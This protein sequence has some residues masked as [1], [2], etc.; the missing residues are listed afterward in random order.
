MIDTLQKQL[1]L[2]LQPL[3]EYREC[4]DIL[5]QQ[6]KNYYLLADDG[7][8]LIGLNLNG[9]QL[10]A[11]QL[12]P[13]WA[14]TTL[15]YLN[16]SDNAFTRLEIPAEMQALVWLEVAD[17]KE[18]K[19]LEF[20]IGLGQLERLDVSDSQL[21]IF[22]LPAAFP[23]LKHIDASRNSIHK[24]D[25]VGILDNL[26]WIDFSNNKLGE[27]NFD[28][29]APSLEELY[30]HRSGLTH[31]QINYPYPKLKKLHL[32]DNKLGDYSMEVW[33]KLPLDME[34]LLYG[35]PLEVDLQIN[36][37]RTDAM[38][39]ISNYFAGCKRGMVKD[40]D[41]KVLVIGNGGVG[42]SS[43]IDRLVYDSFE[44][45]RLSTHAIRIERL[46]E[47]NFFPYNLNFWDFGGQEIYHATH[48]L[49]LHT[50]VIYLL[51]WDKDTEEAARKRLPTRVREVT[52]Y[53]DHPTQDL[54]YYLHYAKYFGKDSPFI[55]VQTKKMKHGGIDLPCPRQTELQSEYH[56]NFIQFCNIDAKETGYRNGFNGLKTALQNAIAHFGR[57]GKKIESWIAVRNHFR[58]VQDDMRERRA[59]KQTVSYQ[60]ATLSLA[61]FGELCDFH[62]VI[63]NNQEYLLNWLKETGVVYFKKDLLGDKIIIDQEWAIQA[64]YTLLERDTTTYYRLSRDQKGRFTGKDLRQIWQKYE[65]NERQ[66]FINFM[67]SCELC[68]E[69]NKSKEWTPFEEREYVAPQLLLAKRTA[70]ASLVSTERQWD[71]YGNRGDFIYLRY[72]RAFLHYGI[73]QSFIIRTYNLAQVEGVYRYG[74]H[75]ILEDEE[76]IVEAPPETNEIRVRAKAGSK[77]LIA[78]IHHLFKNIR[79]REWEESY[80]LDGENYQP[81]PNKEDNEKMDSHYHSAERE[82]RNLFLEVGKESEKRQLEENLFSIPTNN[83]DNS[84]LRVLF[85]TACPPNTDLINS[86]KE[87]LYV[88]KR[89]SD[90]TK[91]KYIDE[92]TPDKMFDTLEAAVEKEIFYKIIHFSGHGSDG[93]TEKAGLLFENEGSNGKLTLDKEQLYE[94][95]LEIQE[96]NPKLEI[97]IFN[98]CFSHEQAKEVS[99]IGIYTIGNELKLQN[100]A[101]RLFSAGFYKEYEAK[102]DIKNAVKLAVRRGIAVDVDM[103]KSVKLY[104]NGEEINYR[105]KTKK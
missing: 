51:L 38:P 78:G 92:V 53:K 29:E 85:L 30:F 75:L 93:A 35:N 47:S 24:I 64:I 9:N 46:E 27:L 1:D 39:F 70:A 28:V 65:H 102:G 5:R 74:I 26:S 7:K 21:E 3:T 73:I 2:P 101:A 57:R 22:S 34:L 59:K 14:C 61:A 98:C 31:F 20:A 69:L 86:D 23:K 103:K 45:N 48:R 16:L 4:K 33:E 79:E 10:T 36:I 94:I 42:K 68:F 54:D 63:N 66:I 13:V 62:K 72:K 32:G 56:E 71:E 80:S 17:C 6:Y 83:L 105:K 12:A 100:E 15:Q 44:E 41:Y 58:K 82:I 11:A 91:F 99:K 18:L 84:L 95:F 40:N 89:T 104:F 76:A 90:N 77:R 43:L 87:Y 8:T 49:F 37:S 25:F 19:I 96:E 97:V 50:N 55:V 52:G 81:L 67:L 88:E 60:D